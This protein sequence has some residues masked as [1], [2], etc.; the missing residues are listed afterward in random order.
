MHVG[1]TEVCCALSKA[2]AAAA[3]PG[4]DLL[5]LECFSFPISSR[6]FESSMRCFGRGKR[7]TTAKMPGDLK[8]SGLLSRSF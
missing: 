7:N 8:G 5:A 2:A 1:R 6:V 4:A 3:E